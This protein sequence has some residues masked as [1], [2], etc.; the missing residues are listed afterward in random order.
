[1]ELIMECIGKDIDE[2][3]RQRIH[4]QDLHALSPDMWPPPRTAIGLKKY[5]QFALTG[6]VWIILGMAVVITTVTSVWMIGPGQEPARVAQDPPARAVQSVPASY[7][8]EVRVIGDAALVLETLPQPAAGQTSREAGVE[9]VSRQVSAGETTGLRDMNTIAAAATTAAALLR[10]HDKAALKVPATTAPGTD[11]PEGGQ[12][13]TREHLDT[14]A[15]VEKEGAWIINLAS[16]SSKADADRFVKKARSR[17][18]ETTQQQV[19]V[20]GKPYWRVQIAGFSTAVEARSY[21]VTAKEKLG[22]RD[23]WITTRL[24]NMM[25]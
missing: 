2:I 13:G 23:V 25:E 6:N 1:M 21:A 18:I 3:R 7:T 14:A 8:P 16:L 10:I 11:S 4:F 5:V 24:K 19:T 12:S 17:N 15:S 20:K 22:L 9:N